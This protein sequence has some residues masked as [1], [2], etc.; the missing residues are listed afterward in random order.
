MLLNLFLD[1]LR[2]Q[3]KSLS[4]PQFEQLWTVFVR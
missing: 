3:N 4:I 1:V 2:A